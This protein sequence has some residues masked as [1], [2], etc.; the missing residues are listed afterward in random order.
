METILNEIEIRILGCLIEKEMTTPDYY[1][2]TLNSLTTACNQKSN[3][4]PIV[5]FDETAVVV[6]LD[7]LRFKG[8]A[9]QA[10][11]EG[12]RVPKYR[13]TLFEKLVL[14]PNQLA[15]LGELLLRGPQTVGELR[16]RAERMHPFADL[17]A[18]DTV[19]GELI[20]RQPPLVCKLPR[21]PGRKEHRFA[22]LLAGPPPVVDDEAPAAE[23]ARLIV[24]AGGERIAQL[25]AEVAALREE[26]AELRQ[27][28]DAFRAQFD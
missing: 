19:L 23:P 28:M 20:E 8:L 7:S 5:N 14:E 13:H 25:E 9:M 2:L 15:I 21:Q 24:A 6:G 3:R 27:Q 16:G 26:V 4:D 1:P 18:V 22:H 17:A 10:H 12:S 11:G